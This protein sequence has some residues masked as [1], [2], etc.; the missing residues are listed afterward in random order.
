MDG[1]QNNGRNWLKVVIIILAILLAVSLL[2]LAATL[3]HRHFSGTEPTS[4]TVPDNIITSDPSDASSVQT[5]GSDESEPETS[6]APEESTAGSADETAVPSQPAPSESGPETTAPAVWL[7]SRNPDDNTP[8]EAA[9]MFPGDA[10]TK[11]YRV[12]VSHKG[13]VT[14][15][16][17]A[18]IRP[19]C[20]KLAEVMKCRV[21]LPETGELL[22]DGLMGDMP[23]SLNHALHTGTS[24]TS[25]VSYEITAYL[26]TGVGNE[27]MNQELIA[28]FNWWVEETE[29]L[30]PPKTG[31]S[32]HI[33]FWAV[34][35]AGS[36]FLLILL[37]RKREKEAAANER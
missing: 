13:D 27:Y 29:N 15:R 33:Y 14:L 6:G 5:D 35:A 30:E 11:Y 17:H 23:Q 4:A 34:L 36:L 10:E 21:V 25:E 31:D 3:I 2:L 26:D 22:Y 37:W 18:D 28:D 24:T 16:F 1:K 12:R 32:F 8:F 9:N 19:G 7:H 20:E